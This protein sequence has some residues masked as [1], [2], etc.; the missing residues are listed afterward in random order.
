[1]VSSHSSRSSSESSE[2]QVPAEDP[3]RLVSDDPIVQPTSNGGAQLPK[4]N[5]HFFSSTSTKNTQTS[6]EIQAQ[7]PRDQSDNTRNSVDEDENPYV[8]RKE[9]RGLFPLICLVPEKKEPHDYHP[10]I[11]DLIVFTIAFAAMVGPMGGSIFLPAMQDISKSLNTTRDIVN[12]SYGLY[13]LSLGIFPLWWSSISEQF[14]R[15]TVYIISFT[16]YVGFLIGCAMS[17]SIGM[18]MGFRILSGAGA[19]AV[20]AVGAGTIG[21]LYVTTQ[22]G[23]AMGYFYLGPLVGPLIGPL[24]GGAIVTKWGWRGTQWFLMIVTSA[25][26]ILLLLV[27]PETLRVE[28]V[29]KQVL[30][31]VVEEEDRKSVV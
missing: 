13:V 11:K 14:G 23:T 4:S 12:I 26:L 2:N 29:P 18:L 16:A 28:L 25:I 31:E 1:M 24:A 5:P 20:Q 17:T 8:P 9:R 7:A 27:L 10:R 15:R 19:A 30:E 6:P 21:D 3:I 22:R